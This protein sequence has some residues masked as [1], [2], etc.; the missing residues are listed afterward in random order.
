MKPCK[1]CGKLTSQGYCLECWVRLL[2]KEK[3]AYGSKD[4]SSRLFWTFT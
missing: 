4:L 3:A 1:K 2:Q